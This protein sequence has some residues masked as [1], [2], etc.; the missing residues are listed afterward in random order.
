MGRIVINEERC[1]GCRLCVHFCPRGLI[2][3]SEQ[4]NS[5]GYHPAVFEGSEECTAC[6]MCAIMCPDVAIE[7]YK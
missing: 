7:V 4:F 1:K 5:K 6:T 2:S 3:V